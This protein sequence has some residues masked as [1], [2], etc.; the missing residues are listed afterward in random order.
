[1]CFTPSILG[2]KSGWRAAVAPDQVAGVDEQWD[3]PGAADVCVGVRGR[4]DQQHGGDRMARIAALRVWERWALLR[5]R[6]MV[7]QE[8]LGGRAGSQRPGVQRY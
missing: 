6:T 7:V 3:L 2:V 4:P 5:V 1:M 8:A